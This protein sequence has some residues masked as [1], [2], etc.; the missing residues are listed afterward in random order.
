MP[1]D[2]N[3][4]ELKEILLLSLKDDGG[5]LRAVYKMPNNLNKSMFFKFDIKAKVKV[6]VASRDMDK[7]QILNL[8]DFESMLVPLN[9]YE[10]TALTSL[11]KVSLITKT[12]IKMG[13]VLTTRQ[14]KTLS[15]I[16]R[17]DQITAIINDGSLSVEI[18]VT[19]LEDANI[20]EIIQVKNE[21]NQ[22]FKATI[23]SKN[24]A[25]IR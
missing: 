18:L 9:K 17:G 25:I 7:G 21:N 13:R 4:Y 20:G 16:K 10:K 14:F 22:I 23:V 19:A 24:R 8:S 2:F 6:F 5:N 12:R 11:P 1:Q 3:E 15:D